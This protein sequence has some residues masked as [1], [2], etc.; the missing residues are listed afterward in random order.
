MKNY[1][2]IEGGVKKTFSWGYVKIYAA[3]EDCFTKDELLRVLED[4]MVL[5]AAGILNSELKAKFTKIKE[6]VKVKFKKP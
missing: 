4:F 3:F 2:E 6:K 1:K 5:D